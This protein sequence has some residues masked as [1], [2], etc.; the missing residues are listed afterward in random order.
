M[1]LAAFTR[2]LSRDDPVLSWLCQVQSQHTREKLHSVGFWQL[3]PRVL[4]TGRRTP[5]VRGGITIAIA[6]GR[7]TLTLAA[8]VAAML[9]VSTVTAQTVSPVYDDTSE[10]RVSIPPEVA[11]SYPHSEAL[12]GL[13][14]YGG[15]LG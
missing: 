4:L 2:L 7:V 6:M 8:V 12:F 11:G 3:A 15:A 5:T 9:A 10:F 1:T 14:S 13:P